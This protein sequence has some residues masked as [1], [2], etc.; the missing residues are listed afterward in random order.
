MPKTNYSKIYK[1]QPE[2]KP[3]NDNVSYTKVQEVVPITGTVANCTKLNVRTKPSADSEV[4]CAI[5]VNSKVVIDETKS[6]PPTWFN[7]CTEAG[8]EGFC[9]S[10]YIQILPFNKD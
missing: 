8:V 3:K 4:L 6:V 5:P 2:D 10:K 9:M 7:V 1:A